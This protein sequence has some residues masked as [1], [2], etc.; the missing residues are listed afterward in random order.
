MPSSEITRSGYRREADDTVQPDHDRAE[1]PVVLRVARNS[2]LPIVEHARLPEADEADEA[3]KETMTLLQRDDV[4][5]HATAHQ[6]KIARVRRNLDLRNSNDQPVPDRGDHALDQRLALPAP[7][8]RIDDV[9]TL[10]PPDDELGDQLRRVLEIAI[11]DHDRVTGGGFHPGDRCHWLTEATRE[12]E[13]LDAWIPRVKR[14]DQLF[15]PVRRRIDAEDQLPFDAQTV[16]N[17][18]QPLVD[19]MDVRL[20]VVSRHDDAQ[21]GAAHGTPRCRTVSPLMPKGRWSRRCSSISLSA[22][23]VREAEVPAMSDATRCSSR[24]P[25]S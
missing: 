16:E 14:Q 9:I 10:P 6:A 1:Q 7:A 12:A 13:Q 24:S 11:D 5:D 18:T 8:L 23:P 20:L 2:G 25:A 22:R 3:A 21:L 19:A 15:G 17:G 4:I